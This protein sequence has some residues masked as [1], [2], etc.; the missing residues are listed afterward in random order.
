ML[1]K[2]LLFSEEI[3]MQT[4]S[5]TLFKTREILYDKESEILLIVKKP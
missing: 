3:G 4:H 2:H 1:S 5:K